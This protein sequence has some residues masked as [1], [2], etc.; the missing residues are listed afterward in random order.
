MEPGLIYRKGLY[1]GLSKGTFYLS[2]RIFFFLWDN[3]FFKP[4]SSEPWVFG[5]NFLD[6]PKT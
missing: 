3:V 2:L 1:F 5:L 4:R 6:T